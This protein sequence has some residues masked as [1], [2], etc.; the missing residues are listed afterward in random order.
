MDKDPVVS[1]ATRP[2]FF[3]FNDK[4]IA[5]LDGDNPWTEWRIYNVI[6]GKRIDHEPLTVT[7]KFETTEST[8]NTCIP[9]LGQCS[10]FNMVLLQSIIPCPVPYKIKRPECNKIENWF[11]RSMFN[12]PAT[13]YDSAILSLNNGKQ[14]ICLG[15]SRIHQKHQLYVCNLELAFMSKKR[16]VSPVTYEAIECDIPFKSSRSYS[17]L[18]AID[19]DNIYI[20]EWQIDVENLKKYLTTIY[21][22]SLSFETTESLETN[23]RQCLQYANICVRDIHM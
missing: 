18:S 16:Q 3:P 10:L 14:F 19:S 6:E 9:D 12:I 11:I 20:M 4:Y 15:T 8:F 2:V 22:C 7:D 23:Y 5:V 21:E 17:L 1:Y 13:I